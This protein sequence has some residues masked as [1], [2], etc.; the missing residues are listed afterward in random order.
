[1]S[2]SKIEN[3]KNQISVTCFRDLLGEIGNRFCS[4]LYLF[5]HLLRKT[6]NVTLQSFS[7]FNY[8]K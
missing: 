7:F 3:R 6:F 1:M 8:V 5:F 4:R 2:E